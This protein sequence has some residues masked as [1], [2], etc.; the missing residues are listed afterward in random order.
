ML[1]TIQKFPALSWQCKKD[2][3]VMVRQIGFQSFFISQSAAETKWPDL[4]EL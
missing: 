3:F 2:V 4:S 1:R